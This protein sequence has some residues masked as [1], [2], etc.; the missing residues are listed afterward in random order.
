MIT[1]GYI[2]VTFSI[3]DYLPTQAEPS[4]TS[5]KPKLHAHTELDISQFELEIDAVHSVVSA[6]ISPRTFLAENTNKY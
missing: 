6:H 1:N 4:P 2:T 5:V 3:V